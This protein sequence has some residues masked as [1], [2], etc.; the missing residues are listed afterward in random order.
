M[1]SVHAR[2]CE[3]LAQALTGGALINARLCGMNAQVDHIL[4]K[5]LGLRPAEGASALFS[6]AHLNSIDL[7]TP[8]LSAW[9]EIAAAR[10]IGGYGS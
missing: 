1:R 6:L 3:G 4:D 7:I 9:K 5:T 8:V 10:R 2:L